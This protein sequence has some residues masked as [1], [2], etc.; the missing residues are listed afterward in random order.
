MR[1]HK[2]PTAKRATYKQY[3]EDGHLLC[4]VKPEDLVTTEVTLDDAKIIVKK[5]HGIDDA[6]V[7]VYIKESR[8]PE[9]M[10]E[11]AKEAKAQYIADFEKRYG[12]KPNPA[13]VP[14]FT[15]R[16]MVSIDAE[17]DTEDGEDSLGD[18]SR[19]AAAMAVR[20]F[21]DEESAAEY[22]RRLV[23]TGNFTERERQVYEAVFI[24]GMAKQDAAKEIG[25]SGPRV[26]EIIGNIMRKIASDE[27]LKKMFR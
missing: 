12:Y 4:E 10:E 3:D 25:I 26:T 17:V 27:E 22:M 15:H 24:K 9:Y 14:D 2:T 21:E 8:L 1:T 5:M 13:D 23:M 11:T 16:A 7:R 18:N 6:E 20:P 19:L